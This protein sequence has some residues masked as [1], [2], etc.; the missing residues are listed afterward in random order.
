MGFGFSEDQLS[1]MPAAVQRLWRLTP[2]ELERHIMDN[3]WFVQPDDLIGGWCITPLPLPPSAGTPQI[4][5][6]LK[7]EVARYIVSL[8]NQRLFA[9][10]QQDG[11]AG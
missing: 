7:E 10:Q 11:E 8:H 3:V 2:E 1:R 9:D 6:F 4:A 5:D